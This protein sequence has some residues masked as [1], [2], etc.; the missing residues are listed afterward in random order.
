MV[1]RKRVR[2]RTIWQPLLMV[3]VLVVILF[4]PFSG[5]GATTAVNRA[6]LDAAFSGDTKKDR[7]GPAGRGC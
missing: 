4:T 5:P 6:F 2:G 7:G 3:S 1:S